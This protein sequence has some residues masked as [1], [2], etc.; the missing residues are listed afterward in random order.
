LYSIAMNISWGSFT[1]AGMFSLNLVWD[2]C[3]LL[4]GIWNWVYSKM[5]SW[6][7][8][9]FRCNFIYVALTFRT[10][11]VSS[12]SKTIILECWIYIEYNL[13]IFVYLYVVL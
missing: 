7:L 3:L 10:K 1:K 6:D 9:I 5:L 12:I 4:M 11:S 13:Y 2:N 8:F